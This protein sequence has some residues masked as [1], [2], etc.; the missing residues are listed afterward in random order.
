MSRSQLPAARS[1]PSSLPK[2]NRKG[3]NHFWQPSGATSKR[4]PLQG[5]TWRSQKRRKRIRNGHQ[6][7]EIPEGWI[8][9]TSKHLC[10]QLPGSPNPAFLPQ[11]YQKMERYSKAQEQVSWAVGPE[12]LQCQIKEEIFNCRRSFASTLHMMSR[13]VQKNLFLFCRESGRRTS[14][15]KRIT[16]FP[17]KPVAPVQPQPRRAH[18]RSRCRSWPGPGSL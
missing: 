18:L 14:M 16:A 13:K 1:R 5:L 11:S 15:F 12:S 7:F 10:P 9:P 3:H 2:G 6:E 4:S 8:S 17:V